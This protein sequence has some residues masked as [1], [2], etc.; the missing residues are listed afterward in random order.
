MTTIFEVCRNKAANGATLLGRIFQ[1]IDWRPLVNKDVLDMRVHNKC[2]LGQL[3][4]YLVT[5]DGIFVP[6]YADAVEWIE[7]HF[8]G[9]SDDWTE[10]WGFDGHLHESEALRDAWLEVMGCA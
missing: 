4:P 3:A 2:I 5:S 6:A 10:A 1:E 9:L 7:A 8:L